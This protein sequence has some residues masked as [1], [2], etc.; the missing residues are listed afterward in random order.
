MND[1]QVMMVIHEIRSVM[2]GGEP[3]IA[4]GS[5]NDGWALFRCDDKF[6]IQKLDEADQFETDQDALIFVIKRASMGDPR[7]L[8]ALCL[9][10]VSL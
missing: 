10:N 8:I 5:M 2:G 7:A 6:E 1:D 3:L 4:C 9:H